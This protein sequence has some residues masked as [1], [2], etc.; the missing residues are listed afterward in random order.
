MQ[1]LKQVNNR[2]GFAAFMALISVSNAVGADIEDISGVVDRADTTG[3][4]V[5]KTGIMWFFAVG[6]PIIS[7]FVMMIVGYITAKKKA[8]NQQEGAGRI[9]GYV[10]GFGIAGVLVYFVVTGVVSQMMFNDS[11]RLFQFIGEWWSNTLK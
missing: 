7:V 6:F 8:D 11:S 10:V 5:L 2:V 9:G 1:I 4:S 3:R